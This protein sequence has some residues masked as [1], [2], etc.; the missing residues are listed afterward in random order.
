MLSFWN[1][2]R[3]ER[4]APEG[5]LVEIWTS[6]PFNHC[7]FTTRPDLDA[8][9]V[10]SFSE[11][12][13]GMSYDNPVHRAVLDAEGLKRW[14]SPQLNGYASLWNASSRQ[15]FFTRPAVAAIEA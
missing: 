15:G 1:V 10:Q 11:A 9:T 13:S 12:L 14:V 5:A 6:P 3:T 7:M 4:L 8:P 2:V